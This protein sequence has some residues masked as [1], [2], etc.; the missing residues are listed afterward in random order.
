MREACERL[1][2]RREGVWRADKTRAQHARRVER[3]LRFVKCGPASE[4]CELVP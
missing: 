2:W 1:G 3:S 4:P